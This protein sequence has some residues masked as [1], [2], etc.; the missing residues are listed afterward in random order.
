MRDVSCCQSRRDADFA[1]LKKP[2]K[3]VTAAAHNMMV[4]GSE[5]VGVQWIL[6]LWRITGVIRRRIFVGLL[7]AWSL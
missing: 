3:Q 4:S 7:W 5:H 1:T 2:K 6:S